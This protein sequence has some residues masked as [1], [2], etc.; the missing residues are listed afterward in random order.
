MR[1]PLAT[2]LAAK[3]VNELCGA[4]YGHTHTTHTVHDNRSAHRPNRG[5]AACRHT[6]TSHTTQPYSLYRRALA[7]TR[8]CKSKR[9][10]DFNV[11]KN[12]SHGEHFIKTRM[13]IMDNIRQ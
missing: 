6:Y 7:Y 4:S 1:P 9:T 13:L 3:Y 11:T 5:A 10:T 12:N 2:Y 8:R